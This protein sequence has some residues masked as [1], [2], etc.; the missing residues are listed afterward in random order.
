MKKAAIAVCAALLAGSAS[1]DS[2]QIGYG[3][4]PVDYRYMITDA[5][6]GFESQGEDSFSLGQLNILYEHSRPVTES[7]KLTL[8]TGVGLP[9]SGGTHEETDLIANLPA[10]LSKNTSNDGDEIEFE[11]FTVPV[12][13]GGK[14]AIPMGDN[15][16]SI[17]LAVGA[18]IIGVQSEDTDVTWT[19]A[20]G[21]ETADVTTVDK[22]TEFAP[23]LAVLGSVGYD[24]PCGEGATLGLSIPVGIIGSRKVMHR[25][26]TDATPSTGNL[27]ATEWGGEVGG[28][29]YG[30]NLAWSKSF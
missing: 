22:G 28:L 21:A 17:G 7:L 18:L 15:T 27:A 11:A 9:L 2:W 5:V 30:V 4:I 25:E 10:G 16:L 1:A 12:L 6:T 23:A 3:A 20:V 19:G 26:E 8:T 14:Y 13:L 24:I 29:A